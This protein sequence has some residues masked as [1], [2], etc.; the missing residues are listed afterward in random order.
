MELTTDNVN[1]TFLDCLFDGNVVVVPDDAVVVDGIMAKFGFDPKKVG[2]NK[3]NIISMLSELPDMFFPETGGGASFL[4]ACENKSGS[5]WTGS[6]SVME[7]LFAL[8]TAVGAV[9][10][11]LPR[12]AWSVLPGGMPYYLVEVN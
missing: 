2:E 1:N 8:G 4:T 11:P 6:H 7:M 3:A 5:Q 10:C 9:K 12:E